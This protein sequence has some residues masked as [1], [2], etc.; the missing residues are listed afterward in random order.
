MDKPDI[1]VV[2]AGP[3]GAVVAARLSEDHSR[4]ILLI[5]AGQD[6]PPGDVPSDIRSA[7]PASYFN[8]GCFWPY[9]ASSLRR[10]EPPVPFLQPRIMGGGS[11]VMGMIAL[12]GLAADFDSPCSSC[13]P[14]VSVVAINVGQRRVIASAL[15][16]V[17]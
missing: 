1:I 11:S 3:A 13:I 17:L 12:P 6:T 16:V 4:R 15:L 9:L 5:E 10:S 14:L 8:S 7:F 2:G